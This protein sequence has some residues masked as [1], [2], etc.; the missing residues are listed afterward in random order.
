MAPRAEAPRKWRRENSW[1]ATVLLGELSWLT[2]NCF[3]LWIAGVLSRA[4][5]EVKSQNRI[6]CRRGQRDNSLAKLRHFPNLN[7]QDKT[8]PKLLDIFAPN[9]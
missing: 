1:R 5:T 6:F 4:Q 9:L 8:P 7:V 2:I 3:K